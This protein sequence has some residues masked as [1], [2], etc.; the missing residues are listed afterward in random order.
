V[1]WVQDTV[2]C[3]FVDSSNLTDC[4]RAPWI[5]M[6]PTQIKV[7]WKLIEWRLVGDLIMKDKRAFVV[8]ED[9]V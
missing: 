1:A 3:E 2:L 7:M 8:E 6:W 9:N 4:S 5:T